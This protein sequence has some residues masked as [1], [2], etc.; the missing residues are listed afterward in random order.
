M[1]MERRQHERYDLRTSVSFSWKDSRGVRQR[2]KGLLSNISGGGFF[3]LTCDSPP[4]GAPIQ[5]VASFRGFFAGTRVVVRAS[6]QVVRVESAAVAERG[7]GFAAAIKH[8]TLRNDQ[9]K[10]N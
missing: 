10:L 2:R 1:Q 3:V 4:E 8:F 5:L 7:A 9:K 6:A